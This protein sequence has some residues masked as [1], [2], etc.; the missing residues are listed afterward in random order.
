VADRILAIIDTDRDG[1]I[2]EAEQRA[3]AN[4][5]LRDV[6]L[7]IDERR[8]APHVVAVSFP[9]IALMK[10]GVGAILIDF[11]AERPPGG[12]TRRLTFENHH[13]SR[14]AAYMTNC[15]VP[16]DPRIRVVAQKRDESQS[17]YQ[18]DIA[19]PEGLAAR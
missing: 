14:I 19:E 5:V 15:S 1:T 11:E 6:S 17:F 13:Q 12:A 18:L 10:E 4:R 2:S 9:D 7:A 3:Y 8:L 16:S